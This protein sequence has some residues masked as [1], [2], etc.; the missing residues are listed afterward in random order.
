[1]V[2]AW[3]I[4]YANTAV[5]APAALVI[6]AAT[7]A[8]SRWQERSSSKAHASS[9]SAGVLN[10]E[11]T[12]QLIK[13]RRSVF[14]KD[15]SGENCLQQGCMAQQALDGS[16][17]LQ[18]LAWAVGQWGWLHHTYLLMTH[19]YPAATLQPAPKHRTFHIVCN[20]TFRTTTSY[21]PIVEQHAK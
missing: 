18:H 17:W 3:A 9:S 7:A 20:D 16:G 11:Q 8:I 14:P 6:L 13:G 2:A 21:A 4:S 5:W 12:L 1:M 10:P 15:F 19:Q